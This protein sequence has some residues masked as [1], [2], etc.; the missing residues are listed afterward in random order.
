MQR[1]SR[2]LGGCPALPHV[3]PGLPGRITS[4]DDVR[5]LTG[6]ERAAHKSE[7]NGIPCNNMLLHVPEPVLAEVSFCGPLCQG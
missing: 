6:L 1:V 2:G 3:R 4:V 5:G 7:R